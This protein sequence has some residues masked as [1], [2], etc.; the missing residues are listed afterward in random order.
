VIIGDKLVDVE[1]GHRA[2][3]LGILVRTGYGEF[4]ELQL[5]DKE[6]QTEPDHVAD[7]VLAGVKWFL[8]RL[9]A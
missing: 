9:N 5:K 3:A 8:E 4:S 1:S 2:G 7:N 6:N